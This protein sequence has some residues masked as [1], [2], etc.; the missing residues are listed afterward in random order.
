[1]LLRKCDITHC[2]SQCEENSGWERSR[3]TKRKS[4]RYGWKQCMP[5]NILVS[6]ERKTR[7]K[8]IRS[9]QEEKK[10]VEK[11]VETD[12]VLSV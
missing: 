8:R 7:R 1:M 9:D 10:G 2:E 5:T 4:E 12:K 11:D 6:R 3:A